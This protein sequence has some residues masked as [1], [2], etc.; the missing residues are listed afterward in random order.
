[1]ELRLRQIG[2]SVGIIL[3]SEV[4]ESLGLKVGDK[5]A[6]SPNEKGYQLSAGDSEFEEQMRR[7]RSL[8][9]RYRSTLRELGK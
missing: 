9:A 2:N 4:L 6:V 5:I 7:G 8:M 3:P 1:M